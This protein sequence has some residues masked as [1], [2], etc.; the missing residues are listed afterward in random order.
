MPSL[1]LKYYHP[2]FYF[3]KQTVFL[4]P[5]ILWYVII[6]IIV[7]APAIGMLF[8]EAFSPSIIRFWR[9]IFDGENRIIE[10]WGYRVFGCSGLL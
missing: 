9:R 6:R 7:Y 4:P 10:G 2:I 8:E 5:Y 3:V 1:N